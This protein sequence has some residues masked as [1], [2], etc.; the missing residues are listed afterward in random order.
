MAKKIIKNTYFKGSSSLKVNDV[1][2]IKK[3]VTSACHDTQHV[4]AYLQPFSC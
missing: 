3:H 1:D 4:S 2:T